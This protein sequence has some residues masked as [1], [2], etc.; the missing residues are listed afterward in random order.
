VLNVSGTVM[1]T[2]RCTLCTFDT[3]VLA[4]QFNDSKWTEQGCNSPRVKEWTLDEGS[5]WAKN[6]YGIPEEVSVTLYE[7]GITGKQLFALV[8]NKLVLYV[9]Y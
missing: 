8:L 6:I 9:Y 3:S 4:Q 2:K 7:N 5:T 1:T